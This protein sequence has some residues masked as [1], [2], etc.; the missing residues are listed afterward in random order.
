MLKVL[1][2]LC[3]RSY[4]V[5]QKAGEKRPVKDPHKT[6]SDQGEAF[7]VNEIEHAV[8]RRFGT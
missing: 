6:S 8:I 1:S 2:D 4:Y 5:L 7:G 3:L